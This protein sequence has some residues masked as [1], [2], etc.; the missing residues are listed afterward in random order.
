M[1]GFITKGFGGSLYTRGANTHTHRH[2][3]LLNVTHALA[4]PLYSVDGG[5][6]DP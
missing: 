3:Q 5:R 4:P 1:F 6:N 2:L